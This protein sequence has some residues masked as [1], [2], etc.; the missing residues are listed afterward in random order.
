MPEAAINTDN[1]ACIPENLRKLN[2]IIILP[3]AFIWGR[4]SR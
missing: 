1:T 2:R 3:R 4:M